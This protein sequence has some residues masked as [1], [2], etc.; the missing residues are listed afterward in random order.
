MWA[1]I[2]H[3][4]QEKDKEDSYLQHTNNKHLSINQK[5]GCYLR[6]WPLNC[7]TNTSFSILSPPVEQQNWS[8]PQTH[9]QWPPLASDWL[10]C[11]ITEREVITDALISSTRAF[12]DALVR[13]AD[14]SDLSA[15]ITVSGTRLETCACD[16]VSY[17]LRWDVCITHKPHRWCCDILSHSCQ[18]Y[19]S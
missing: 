5:N 18:Y 19:F 15:S 9:A 2:L 10:T 12:P 4:L 11:C 17:P 6:N 1:W 16:P 7:I 8:H 3:D 14:D 13:S